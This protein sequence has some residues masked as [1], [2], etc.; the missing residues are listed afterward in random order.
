MTRCARRTATASPRRPWRWC[1]AITPAPMSTRRSSSTPIPRPLP[2]DQ[3]PL[4]NFFTEA[5]CLDLSHKPLKSDISIEDLEKA[6]KAAGVDD[7]AEGHGAAAHGFL[8]PHPRQAGLHHRLSGADQGI[9]D[10]ARQEGHRHVRRRGG[11][12]GP[13]RPQQFRGASRLPR[14]RLHAHGGAGQSRQA[15]R[16]GPLPLHR[17]SDQDQG[18][19]RRADPRGGVA[20]WRERRLRSR[21]APDSRQ[22]S[23]PLAALRGSVGQRRRPARPQLR[24]RREV[25]PGTRGRNALRRLAQ[26][27]RPADRRLREADLLSDPAGRRGAGAGGAPISSRAG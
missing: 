18:R 8:P 10:L 25:V 24:R 22:P 23:S 11:E 21:L 14:S 12:P 3:V 9:G 5:V 4:E 26:F 19:H 7:Q 20:R 2:I 15:R 16:Q 6:E 13:A 1:W 27:R 17:L